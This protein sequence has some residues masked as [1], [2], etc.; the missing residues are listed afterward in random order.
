MRKQWMFRVSLLLSSFLILVGCNGF[1]KG[2]KQGLF[3]TQKQALTSSVSFWIAGE[4]E[5][6][7]RGPIP[8]WLTTTNRK[9]WDGTTVKIFGARNEIVG[10]QVF[11][12]STESLSGMDLTVSALSNGSHQITNTST[13]PTT[14]VGRPIQRYVQHYMHVSRASGGPSGSLFWSQA[15]APTGFVGQDVPDALIPFEVM[16]NKTGE[17]FSLT[18]NQLQGIWVDVSI[19]KGT[20]AGTYTGTIT[21]TSN[22]GQVERTIPISLQV[23]CFTLPDKILAKNMLYIDMAEVYWRHGTDAGT[24][25]GNL[26]LK[27]YYQML[28]RHR[29]TP[30]ESLYST[31]YA[32]LRKS[33]YDGTAF[34]ASEGYAGPGENTGVD[35]F[36]IATYGSWYWGGYDDATLQS[37]GDTWVNWLNTNAPNLERFLYVMDEPDPSATTASRVRAFC[38]AFKNHT[39]PSAGLNRMITTN[40]RASMVAAVTTWTTG[41]RGYKLDDV[42]KVCQFGH[43][44]WIYNG[45]RPMT[46]TFVNDDVGVSPRV[47]PWIQYKHGIPRWYFWSGNYWSDWQGGRGRLDP[48]AVSENF[49]NSYGEWGV[50]DGVLFYPGEQPSEFAANDYGFEGA[51]PSIRL[52]NWRRGIQDYAY[53]A[54]A[55]NVDQTSVNQIVQNMVPTAVSQTNEQSAVSWSE[56]GD[57]WAHAR[58]QLAD[59]IAGSCATGG[60]GTATAAAE[61]TSSCPYANVTVKDGNWSDP[62]TW[63]DGLVPDNTHPIFTAHA[64]VINQDLTIGTTPTDSTYA[65]L[66]V[67]GPTSSLRITPNTKVTMKGNIFVS[68]ASFTVADGATLEFDVPAGKKYQLRVGTAN[69]EEAYLFLLGTANNRINLLSKSGGGIVQITGGGTYTHDNTG[70][71]RSGGQVLAYYTNFT[72]IG[73]ANNYAHARYPGWYPT[74]YIFHNNIMDTCGEFMGTGFD[75]AYANV[76]FI[77]N[78]FK[79]SQGSRSLHIAHWQGTPEGTRIVRGNVFDKV[80]HFYTAAEYE[81]KDNYFAQSFVMSPGAPTVF[82][83]NLVRKTTSAA[84]GIQAK[85]TLIENNYFLNDHENP[86][87]QAITP[88]GDGGEATIRGNVMEAVGPGRWGADIV[89]NNYP[90]S[91]GTLHIEQNIQLPNAN[92]VS[93][94]NFMIFHGSANL[95]A[96]IKRNTYMTESLGIFVGLYYLGHTGM[97]GSFHSNLAW[98]S[99]P[100]GGNLLFYNLGGTWAATDLLAASA[101]KNNNSYL[102]VAGSNGNG[103]HNMN[104]SEGGVGETDLHVN[105]QFVD[106]SRNIA[107]WDQSLGGTGATKAERRANA[108]AKIASMHEDGADP[109]YT[110]ASL[111]QYVKAGFAPTNQALKQAGAPSDGSP[112]I[113]A[114]DVVDP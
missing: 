36:S 87:A 84:V 66:T 1:E 32:D 63:K 60:P 41:A 10:F 81:I 97:I 33:M 26:L 43:K 16:Q 88:M 4:S 39:G 78:T 59:L 8:S 20:P 38:D 29:I 15:A 3:S 44:Q 93:P 95:T 86:Y 104:F 13:D 40:F 101:I 17:S 64:V 11:L 74:Y 12:K 9:V 108:L 23:Y 67:I 99:V 65:D 111:L 94:G 69:D 14:S 70:G 110:I 34:Q 31:A 6:V 50:G 24:P 80:V 28:H 77:N 2:Q 114:V 76:E 56:R 89:L 61:N 47:N 83:G 30:I 45:Y 19:P 25:K 62:T 51:F 54:L 49:R 21:V 58:Q 73:D 107:K 37:M 103:Y 5:K 48:F 46:G 90:T 71:W 52:K 57:T 27:R 53:L 75:G 18:Q 91:P 102:N 100:T 96:H 42:V 35:I 98:A 79:N 72:R 82:S 7:T 112:D 109:S 106:V 113:G 68:D 85:N 92:G 55:K 22:N 105:P